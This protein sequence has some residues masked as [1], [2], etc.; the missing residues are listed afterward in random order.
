MKIGKKMQEW[1]EASDELE[2]IYLQKG[3]TSC[4]L[5]FPGCWRTT[6]L[7]FAH[8]YKRN[9]PRCEHTFEGTIL[10]DNNCHQIIEYD[11]ELTEDVFKKLR[12]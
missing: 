2:E 11:R 1:I 12:P 8:R 5:N 9:D 6:A 10:A 4:E 3:I 7:H